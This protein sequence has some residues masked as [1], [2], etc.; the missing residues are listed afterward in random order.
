MASLDKQVKVAKEVSEVL[1]CV[2]V[3]VQSALDKKPA[4]QVISD[5]VAPLMAALDGIGNVSEELKLQREEVY[6]A[7]ALF[8]SALASK[9][10][11]PAA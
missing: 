11:G 4:V 6:N 5:A 9:L 1:D 2:L 10:S 3:L 8:L 7:G